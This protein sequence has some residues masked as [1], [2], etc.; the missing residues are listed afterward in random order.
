MAVPVWCKR[1]DGQLPSWCELRDWEEAKYPFC[2][3]CSKYATDEH[4]SG[5]QHER[6]LE[7]S[8]AA[9]AELP[10]E[11]DEEDFELRNDEL[12]CL[13]CH[14]YAKDL[15]GRSCNQR[16]TQIGGDCSHFSTS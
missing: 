2:T 4:V 8:R 12:F 16:I 14:K 10:P 13:L 5:G 9:P 15:C 6:K 7:Y 11:L 3:L 1:L